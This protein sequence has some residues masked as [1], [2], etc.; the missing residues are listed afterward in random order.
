M[1]EPMELL[2]EDF[3]LVA[4]GI[5]DECHFSFPRGELFLPAAGPDLDTVVL[6]LATVFHDVGYTHGG[7]HQILGKGHIVVRRI[8]EFQ[9]MLVARQV[10]KGELVPLR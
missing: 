6:K 2:F 3:H 10:Q 7:M 9:E 1:W 8:R 4:V 5:G